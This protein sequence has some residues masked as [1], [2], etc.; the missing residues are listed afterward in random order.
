MTN[1]LGQNTERICREKKPRP[2]EGAGLKS[3][4]LTVFF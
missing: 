2:C 1:S 4:V 3:M